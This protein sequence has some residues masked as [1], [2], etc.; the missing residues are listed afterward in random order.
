MFLL[1]T[2]RKRQNSKGLPPSS[3]KDSAIIGD[4]GLVE[5]EDNKVDLGNVML[6]EANSNKAEVSNF[7]CILGTIGLDIKRNGQVYISCAAGNC[8]SNLHARKEV[9]EMTKQEAKVLKKTGEEEA[10]Y[11]VLKKVSKRR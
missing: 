11:Y 8:A 9:S 10:N 5:K 1:P 6:D 7:V 2:N 3:K 4:V